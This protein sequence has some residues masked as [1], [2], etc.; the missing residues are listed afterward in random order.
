YPAD[1]VRCAIP[2]TPYRV[3]IRAPSPVCISAG[4]DISRSV[5]VSVTRLNLPTIFARLFGQS[6]WDV[7]QAAVAGLYNI[8]KY[9][10]ST[11]RPPKPQQNGS[12]ANF[13]DISVQG[14]NTLLQVLVGDMDT[15]TTAN[16]S[17]GGG[18]ALDRGF[19]L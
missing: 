15:H 14:T 10:V 5:L 11:L 2:N 8:G 18:V 12:D 16:V 4:C 7:S 17:G 3:S 1:V 13:D 9:A 19:V 6:G